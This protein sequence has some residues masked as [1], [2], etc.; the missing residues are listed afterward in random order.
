M[1]WG[2]RDLKRL[3]KLSGLHHQ[4]WM[5]IAVIQAI[6]WIA[7]PRRDDKIFAYVNRPFQFLPIPWRCNLSLGQSLWIFLWIPEA[8]TC[9]FLVHFAILKHRIELLQACLSL[10]GSRIFSW[11]KPLRQTLSIYELICPFFV[12][13]CSGL[14]DFQRW[15]TSLCCANWKDWRHLFIPF[16]HYSNKIIALTMSYVYL[17]STPKVSYLQGNIVFV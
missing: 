6:F 4:H 17:S 16:I 7:P 2:G 9:L 1:E 12:Y 13:N 5:R 15:C 14:S 10:I 11:V 3:G 8:Y